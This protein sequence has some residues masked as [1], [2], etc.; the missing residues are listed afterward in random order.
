[1]CAH[2]PR[3]PARDSDA[4]RR[5]GLKPSGGE[6]TLLPGPGGASG[7]EQ[8]TRKL[9]GNAKARAIRAEP[10]P[11]PGHATG[12]WDRE[13]EA[14]G[15]KPKCVMPARESGCGASGRKKGKGTGA[16]R[17]L[18]DGGPG[19]GDPGGSFGGLGYGE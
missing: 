14:R 2:D 8:L 10:E 7:G 11:R 15:C 1:M 13:R 12:R 17:R 6:W 19:A 5:W 3:S 9:Q 4:E 18:R 16:L